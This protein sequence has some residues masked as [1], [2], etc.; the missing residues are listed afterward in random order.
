MNVLSH[1]YGE[2]DSSAAPSP[3]SPWDD[4]LDT[5]GTTPKGEV[6][7]ARSRRSRAI[8]GAIAEGR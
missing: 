2:L 4:C 1:L 7:R 8:Q 5:G 3:F 6:D